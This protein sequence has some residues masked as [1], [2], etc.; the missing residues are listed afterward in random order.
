MFKIQ[1]K[2]FTWKKE[3]SSYEEAIL[4]AESLQLRL[5]LIGRT[6]VY[7]NDKIGWII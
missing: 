6:Y 4:I 2:Q 1:H 7:F 5:G 3:A